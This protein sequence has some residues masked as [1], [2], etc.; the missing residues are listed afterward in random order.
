MPPSK[1]WALF[2]E[3]RKLMPTQ[4]K[5]LARDHTAREQPGSRASTFHDEAVRGLMTKGACSNGRKCTEGTRKARKTLV[6][7]VITPRLSQNAQNKEEMSRKVKQR[8]AGWDHLTHL[9][10]PNV[11]Q[12]TQWQQT[13][14]VHGR[15]PREPAPCPALTTSLH[16]NKGPP[17]EQIPHPRPRPTAQGQ[18]RSR[19]TIKCVEDE[20]KPVV[21][22]E[23]SPFYSEGY[24]GLRVNCPGSQSW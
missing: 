12:W 3:M 16:L 7:R 18:A 11:L 9:Y 6:R 22:T 10:F 5:E 21:G 4:V 24:W 13:Q 19:H 1:R 23:V 15:R 2:L 14:P 8:L 17:T 20:S